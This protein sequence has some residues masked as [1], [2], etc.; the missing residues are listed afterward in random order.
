MKWHETESAEE[1]KA[2]A[3]EF[4]NK[5]AGVH[6]PEKSISPTFS[7]YISLYF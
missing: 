2:Q 4:Q 3:G 6:L 5:R 7:F 1:L